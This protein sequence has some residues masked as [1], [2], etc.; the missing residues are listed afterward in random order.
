MNEFKSKYDFY[1][2]EYFVDD[3][4][5]LKIAAKKLNYSPKHLIELVRLKRYHGFKCKS[6]WF[7]VLPKN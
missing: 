3:A 2:G 4:V 5:P 6:K 1:W 7:V